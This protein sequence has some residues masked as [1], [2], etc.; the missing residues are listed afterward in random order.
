MPREI[1]YALLERNLASVLP[2]S[3]SSPIP[4]ACSLTEPTPVFT[5]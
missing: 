4:C 2:R 1:D 5:G 3:G